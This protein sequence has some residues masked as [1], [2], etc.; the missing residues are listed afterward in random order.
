MRTE[1]QMF[2]IIVVIIFYYVMFFTSHYVFERESEKFSKVLYVEFVKP[3][4]GNPSP[5][6]PWEKGQE[7]VH[8]YQ[9]ASI[10][11]RQIQCWKDPMLVSHVYKDM[12]EKSNTVSGF[13]RIHENLNHARLD[14]DLICYYKQK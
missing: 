3:L 8:Y 14:Y 1:K 2:Y 10:Q 4:L 7:V 12:V 5:P 6:P 11:K 9:N 13:I